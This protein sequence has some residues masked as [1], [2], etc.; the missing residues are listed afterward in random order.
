VNAAPHRNEDRI[1]FGLAMR[2]LAVLLL[3][4]MSALIKLAEVRGA[5]LPEIM[6][7]RQGIAI[8]VVLGMMAIGPGLGAVRTGAFRGQFIR[9]AVGTTGMFFTFGTLLLL[10]LAEATTLSFTTPIFAT[11]LGAVVLREATGWHRWSAVAVGFLGVVVVTQPGS[12]HFPLAGT[13]CGLVAALF[14]AMVAI[15]LR[16]VGKID[17]PLTTVFWFS[18]LSSIPLG[19]L[20]LFFAR[21]HDETTFAILTGIGISGGFG[22]IAFSSAMRY[23]PV[24]TVMPMDYSGLVWATVFGWILFGALPTPMTWVGAPI[25]ILSGLYIVWREHRLGRANALAAASTAP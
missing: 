15:Q 21:M 10:P 8:P 6:F 11:I 12:N 3:S 23:A 19:I 7:F 1:L 24:S 4:A 16:R 5:T 13:A 17:R 18:A 20:Y 25:I 22:Q 14:V 2:L 9:A